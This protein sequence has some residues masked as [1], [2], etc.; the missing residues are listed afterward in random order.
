MLTQTTL[1]SE[2]Q[3]TIDVVTSKIVEVC[4]AISNQNAPSLT[5]RNNS[6]NAQQCEHQQQ[7]MQCDTTTPLDLW[8]HKR[9]AKFNTTAVYVKQNG[10][11]TS[12]AQ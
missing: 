4:A 5:K 3:I 2:S 1:S 8:K 7:W 11:P 9:M 12:M 6:N 10:A